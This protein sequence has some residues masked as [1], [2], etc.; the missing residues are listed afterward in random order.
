MLVEYCVDPVAELL[1]TIYQNDGSGLSFSSMEE[2]FGK[3][4]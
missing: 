2:I 3:V 1:F 4:S